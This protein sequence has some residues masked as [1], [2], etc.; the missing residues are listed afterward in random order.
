MRCIFIEILK[1]IEYGEEG[2]EFVIW[3]CILE[4]LQLFE[5]NWNAVLL[6]VVFYFPFENRGPR[7][8]CIIKYFLL[9]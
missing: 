2:K 6:G 7:E 1:M 9:H 4:L 5:T 3:T 8:L